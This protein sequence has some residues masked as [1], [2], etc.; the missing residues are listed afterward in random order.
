MSVGSRRVHTRA[1][2]GPDGRRPGLEEWHAEEAP[3]A[4]PTV[5]ASPA[6]GSAAPI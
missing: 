3:V 5:Q 6:A 2:V 4:S 1:E